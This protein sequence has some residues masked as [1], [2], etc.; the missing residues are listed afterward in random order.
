M[1]Q[2]P[3]PATWPLSTPIRAQM[4]AITPVARHPNIARPGPDPSIL[5]SF[6]SSVIGLLVSKW[7]HYQ[8]ECNCDRELYNRTFSRVADLPTTKRVAICKADAGRDAKESE[9]RIPPPVGPGRGARLK[10]AS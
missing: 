10:I 8:P 9:H 2:T 4:Q 5:L 1:R 6:L 7:Q 3:A